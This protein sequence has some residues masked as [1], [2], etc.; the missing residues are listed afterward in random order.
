MFLSKCVEKRKQMGLAG[1]R[2]VEKE[3]NRQIVIDKNN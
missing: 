2:K 3:F 1:S